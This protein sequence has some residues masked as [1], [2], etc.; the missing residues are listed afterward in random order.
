MW[1]Q[2]SLQNPSTWEA[3]AN[4]SL[5]SRSTWTARTTQRNPISKQTIHQL[6]GLTLTSM[7]CHST[8]SIKNSSQIAKLR[9]PE[10]LNTGTFYPIKQVYAHSGLTDLER[11]LVS[12]HM[13][14]HLFWS[15][16]LAKGKSSHPQTIYSSKN[17]V[18]HSVPSKAVLFSIS[19]P[20]VKN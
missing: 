9:H 14:L 18:F 3:E 12:R 10:G 20:G 17:E 5:R 8:V 11:V 13:H 7:Q 19:K 6:P 2:P 1:P 15:V 4:G 16:S